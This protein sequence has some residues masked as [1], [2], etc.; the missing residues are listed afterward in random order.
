MVNTDSC[1]TGDINASKECG[2]AG[3][4]FVKITEPVETRV[5][6]RDTSFLRMRYKLTRIAHK[7]RFT[8]PQD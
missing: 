3:S 2:H 8:S 5:W 4:W 1:Q 7:R 6:D